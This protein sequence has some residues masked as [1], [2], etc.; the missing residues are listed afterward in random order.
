M[1]IVLI[2][3]VLALIIYFLYY[4]DYGEVLKVFNTL[5]K[6]LD[7]RDLLVMKLV[8]E[9]KDKKEQAEVVSLIEMR[10]KNKKK[11]FT[12][13]MMLDVKLNEEL[14]RFYELINKKN[15]NPVISETFKSVIEVEKKLKKLRNEFNNVVEKYNMNLVM[16][17]FVCVRIIHMKPLDKYTVA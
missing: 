4:K 7:I 15:D 10:M 13:K 17:K 9:I 16:H 5:E 1:V 11:S 2:G 12:E 8:P 14:K 6:T 3:I